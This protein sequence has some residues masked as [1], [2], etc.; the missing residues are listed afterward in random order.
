M[1][2][3]FI[4]RIQK[5][6]QIFF[7]CCRYQGES[8]NGQDALYACR[9]QQ[10][11]TECEHASTRPLYPRG[12]TRVHTRRSHTHAYMHTRRSYAYSKHAYPARA[13]GRLFC[14]PRAQGASSGTL[15]RAAPRTPSSPWASCRSVRVAVLILSAV[16]G[17]VPVTTWP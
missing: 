11:M 10:L 8:N 13:H 6:K 3:K 2:S 15:G 7:F 14:W 1:N 16:C 4:F 17:A 9:Y 5:I 12:R